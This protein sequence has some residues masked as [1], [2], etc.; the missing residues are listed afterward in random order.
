[1]ENFARDRRDRGS[2]VVLCFLG[3]LACVLFLSAVPARAQERVKVRAAY[4]SPSGVFIPFWIQKEKGLDR[5]YGLDEELIFIAGGSKVAQ[6]MLSGELQFA[7]MGAGLVEADLEGADLIYVA[8]PIDRFVFSLYA[9]PSI[10]S[11]ADLKGKIVGA[12]RVATATWYAAIEA[13]KRFGFEKGRDYRLLQTGGVPETLAAI[14]T[15]K[16][17]A[18]IVSPPTTLKARR[19]GLKE[20]VNLGDLNLP[21]VQ[22]GIVVRRSYLRDHPRA[23]EDFLKGFVAAIH[24]IKTDRAYTERIIGKY[25]RTKDPEILAE[26]YRAFAG[27]FPRDPLPSRAAVERMVE[28]AASVNSR[29]KSASPEEFYDSRIL[30]HLEKSGFVSGFYR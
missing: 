28:V 27:R 17:Q 22:S 8:T 25:T 23:V 9:R 26:T 30:E 16:V 20:L 7:G 10:R 19:A 3:V 4:S 29:A 1:M 11:V 21:F 6:V 13:M 2:A 18:G 5:K 15:G 12:T 14:K 24:V